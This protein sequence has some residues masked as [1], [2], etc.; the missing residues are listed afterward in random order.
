[1]PP[2]RTPDE[3][4][5]LLRRETRWKHGAVPLE[6]GG[7][8]V[9]PGFRLFD[10]GRYLFRSDTG[11]GYLYEPGQ[12]ITIERPEHVDPDEES[13]WLNGNVYA[14]V[15]CLHHF[16]P[17]HASA[18]AHEGRV[19]AFTGASGAGKSTLIAGLGTLGLPMF[20]DDTMLLD[21][22]DP[23]RVTALPGH[24]RLKLTPQAMALTGTS[25]EQ[26]VGA[27]TAKHYVRPPAGD[28]GIPLPLHRL[29]FLEEGPALHWEPITGAQRLVRLED[30]HYT[31]QLWLEAQAPTRA[32][33]FAM[34]GRL[35]RQIAMARLARPR[36]PGHFTASLELAA[37]QIRGLEQ[38]QAA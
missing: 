19:T 33:I 27:D 35:A 18:V 3:A 26:P 17:L 36:S 25:G 30:D 22:S 16:L 10:Q 2:V 13:L 24:K 12:G 6:L 21:L 23:A 8:Q 29:V 11:Y 1:M 7:H 9:D 38:E 4:L 5:Q 37:R 20:C 32:E 28:V 15:A 14:A 34:R 31:W